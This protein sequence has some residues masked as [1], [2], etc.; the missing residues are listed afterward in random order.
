MKLTNIAIRDFRSLFVDDRSQ[1]F[2]VDLAD[3][4]NTFVGRNNCGKS[5]VLRAVAA[6]LDPAYPYDRVADTPGPRQFSHPVITLAFDASGGSGEEAE[7]L[8]LARNYETAISPGGKLNADSGRIILEVSFPP[9]E[10][11]NA[12]RREVILGTRD[13][14]PTT[15]QGREAGAVVIDKLRSTVGFV[16]ISSGESLESVLEGNFRAILHSVI[17]D[18]L[19]ED[20]ERAEQS[21]QDYIT[22]LQDNLLGPLRKQLS[23]VLTS[24][25]PEIDDITLAPT[26]SEI[27]A[28]LSN[29]GVSVHDLVDTPLTAKG[30]GVRG[31]VLV[32]MFRYLAENATRGMVFALEEP[33][34]FLHPAAQEDLRDNLEFL[35]SSQDVSLLLTTHSPFVVTRSP[36]GRVFALGKDTA[37]RT[38]LAGRCNGDEPHA[39]LIGDLFREVTFQELIAQATSLPDHINGVL[40]VEGEGDAAYLRLAAERAGRPELLA[41]IMVRPSGGTTGMATLAV[42]TRSATDKPLAILLDNDAPG[43]QAATLLK[44][45]FGMKPSKEV[46][47]IGLL[48][49]EKERAFGF[50]AEDLFPPFLIEQFLEANGGENDLIDGKQRRPDGAW[51]YD[52]NSACKLALFEYLERELRPDHLDQWI[53]L[54]ELVRTRLGLPAPEPTARPEPEETPTAATAVSDAVVV[55]TDR[56]LYP[57]YLRTSAIVLDPEETVPDG[58]GHIAFYTD[59]AVQNEVPSVVARYGHLLFSA[60]TVLQLRESGKAPDAAVADLVKDALDVDDAKAGKP[61]QVLILSAPD[62][63]ATLVL[64]QPI[65]NT[66]TTSRGKAMAWAV[67]QRTTSLAALAKGPATTDELEELGG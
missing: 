32:A 6:A 7:L 61:W 13:A 27:E 28:T 52:L 15:P 16:L 41:D 19:S 34:A 55:L 23:N 24:L 53:A 46:I 66:K 44:D 30:T 14:R 49:P 62:D 25:F 4:M 35:A 48:F 2:S 22:G 11:G 47:S 20:F 65:T 67:G 8:E 17:R 59:G 5:N 26:V 45:K 56:L 40:L 43:K 63:P 29:V 60:E 21:R 9:D 1:A 64:E 54:L 39:P 37:G 50:E 42:L 57:E 51:H 18:R 10:D 33:E 31:G 3:G 58:I 38:R 36:S 12:V